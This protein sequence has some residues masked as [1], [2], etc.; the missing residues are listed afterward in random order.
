MK[1]PEVQP[2]NLGEGHWSQSGR[3]TTNAATTTESA[4][5]ETRWDLIVAVHL[6]FVSVRRRFTGGRPRACGGP[7]FMIML[8]ANSRAGVPG[9]GE[10]RGLP[11]ITETNDGPLPAAL[12]DRTKSKAAGP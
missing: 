9:M 2:L 7:A 11:V 5:P 6:A 1:R 10:L 8:R 12:V 4:S 3:S